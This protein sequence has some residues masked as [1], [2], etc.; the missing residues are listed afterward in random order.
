[1]SSPLINLEKYQIILASGSPRRKELLKGLGIIF[2][3]RADHDLDESFP[4]DLHPASVAEFLAQ[5]KAAHYRKS[6]ADNE[7]IITADTVVISGSDILNKPTDRQDAIDML[8]LLSG[9]T[10]EVITGVCLTTKHKQVAFSSV[11]DVTFCRLTP[12]E[13]TYYVDNFRPFDKAGAYG[14][15]EWIGFI[16]VEKINGSFYNVMGLPVQKLYQELKKF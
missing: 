7:L 1:M 2:N 8:T 10:H 4:H 13:T 14:I 16:G 15:Q 12:Q 9:K 5:K 3:T 11:S 6:M